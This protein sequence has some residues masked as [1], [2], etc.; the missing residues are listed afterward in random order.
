[1]SERPP[2]VSVVTPVYNGEQFLRE[3]IESVLAQTYPHWDYTIVNNCSTDG[4]RA[5]AQ[6]YADRDPR[7]RIVDNTTF[8]RAIEN[9]NNAFRQISPDSTYCKVVAADDWLFPECLER[10]VA[11]AEAHPRVRIVGSYA[12]AHATL[13]WDEV[14]PYPSTAVPGREVCRKRLLGGRSVF[15]NPTVL[16][17]RS[18]I[19]R[20]KPAFFDVAEELHAD[21]AV[22]YEFLVDH[23]F[24]FVHQVLTY[25]RVREGS[26]TSLS[27][28]LN[29]YVTNRLYE[30]VTFGPRYLTAD[31]LERRIREQLRVY[32]AFLG[33]Q[34]L[35]MREARFWNYHRAKLAGLGHPLQPLRVA[36]SAVGFVLDRVLNPKDSIERLARWVGNTLRARRDAAEARRRGAAG[37]QGTG[38]AEAAA[39]D[40]K[41][42]GGDA[43]GSAR[44]P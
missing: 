23:D 11:V 27:V 8:V 29:S 18:D 40:G 3:C 10:M 20:S 31:E 13:E 6:E 9:Y 28:V 24:G 38:D 37:P 16:L 12:L 7:I 39:I 1:M 35:K 32:Y 25:R 30:L 2:H 41:G 21:T 22:C 4:T 15:G 19:V 36:A 42:P 14:L 17:F 44:R 33:V 43:A 34:A 26:L 5:I